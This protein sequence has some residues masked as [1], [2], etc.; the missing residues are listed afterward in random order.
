[1]N[2]AAGPAAAPPPAEIFRPRPARRAPPS[3]LGVQGWIR[4]NMFSS[5]PNALVTVIGIWIVYAFFDALFGWA[6]G[7]AVWQAESRREC[8]DEV[9]RAGACWPGVIAWIPNL[10]YGLYPKDQ[11]WRINLAGL[12]LLL[13]AAP[14]WL[15]RVQS[16]VQIGLSLVL[17]FPLF[18]SYLFLGG[19]KGIVWSA[20]IALGLA[21]FLWTLLTAVTETVFGL[22]IAR[23]A[24]AALGFGGQSDEAR[25][26]LAIAVLLAIYVVAVIAVQALSL[27]FVPTR[28]WGGL[29]LTLVISGIGIAFSLPAGIV[30]ALGRRSRM[31]LISLLSTTFIELFRSVPLITILFMFNTMLPLFLPVGVEVNQLLRAIVAVCLFS[32]AYMAEVVRGGLQA[33]PRGQYEAASAMGL[34]FWQATGLVIMPQALKIMIPTIVGNFIGLFKDTTLVSIV[35]LFDLL[36]MSRAVGEDTRWLG[37]FLEPFFFVTMIYFV[38]CFGMSQYSLNLEQ[39]LSAGERR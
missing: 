35:G 36:S 21:A 13:W 4:Q 6:V 34:G 26:R 1:M 39:R 11:V 22:G 18:A 31:P 5:V 14:L 2:H 10:I 25:R 32:A 9:G 7:N 38:V 15:P 19:E 27:P 23:F 3:T 24:V 17:L 37:L 8:L 12:V 30:L 28:V 29:F 20:L 33:I 16:K